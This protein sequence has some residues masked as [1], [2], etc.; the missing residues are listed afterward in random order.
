MS[1][2][3]IA[4]SGGLND[5]WLYRVGGI[6]AIA[7]AIGYIIIIPLFAHVGAPPIGGDGEAW[8]RYLE[9][10]TTVW[11]SILSVSV[12]T[13]FL[14]IPVAFSLYLALKRANRCAMLVATALL[15]LFVALD[16]A[17][18]WTNYASL[19]TLTGWHTAA[20]NDLQR[21]A[22]VAAASY[23]SAVVGSHLFVF[24]AIVTPSFGVLLI[25]FAMFKRTR[26]FGKATAYLGLATG[27]SGIASPTGFFAMIL[28]NSLLATVWFLFV[29]YRLLRVSRSS[30]PIEEWRAAQV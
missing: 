19:L 20:T 22:V 17:V 14:Y 8:I 4:E 2:E 12:L 18:T 27:I 28:L 21:A 25:G 13:D 16:L 6:S 3:K 7:V 10:K 9:G 15:G 11:W 30:F 23:A 29:G 24:Y 1:A 5:R 26:T